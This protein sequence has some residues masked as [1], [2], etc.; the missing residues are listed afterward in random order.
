MEPE[1]EVQE[2][3]LREVM[4]YLGLARLRQVPAE[5]RGGDQGNRQR[6]ELWILGGGASP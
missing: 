2:P 5:E 1:Q 4:V 6:G 3:R